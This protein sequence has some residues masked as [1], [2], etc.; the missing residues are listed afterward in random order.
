MSCILSGKP[1]SNRWESWSSEMVGLEH[2]NLT[3]R[4]KT[5]LK[6]YHSF[7][8]SVLICRREGAGTKFFEGPFLSHCSVSLG[9]QLEPSINSTNSRTLSWCQILTVHHKDKQDWSSSCPLG[10]GQVSGKTQI[11]WVPTAG[12]GNYDGE[13][14]GAA[15][16]SRVPPHLV[17][18]DSIE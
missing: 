13:K 6:N 12:E 14:L 11:K 15:G 18:E 10:C 3:T 9:S 7:M 8:L 16:T 17:Q 4:T 2:S 1:A 5:K